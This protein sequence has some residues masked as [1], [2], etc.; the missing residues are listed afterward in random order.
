MRFIIRIVSVRDPYRS[1]SDGRP[2]QQR[3]G[4]AFGPSYGESGD[5]AAL[6]P[7]LDGILVEN[8]GTVEATLPLFPS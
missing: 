7:C 4:Q 3:L 1:P 2:D 5:T 8:A 6:D